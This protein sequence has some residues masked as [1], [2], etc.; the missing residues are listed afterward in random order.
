ME[1]KRQKID[2]KFLNK[3]RLFY[4]VM[5][6]VFENEEIEI[7][8]EDFTHDN[9]IINNPIGENILKY[10]YLPTSRFFS[11]D[12]YQNMVNKG[13]VGQ[14]DTTLAPYPFK[15]YGAYFGRIDLYTKL[16]LVSF[17]IDKPLLNG[18]NDLQY[19]EDF[20]PYFRDYANGFKDGYDNFENK[21]ISPFLPMFADKQDYINKVHEYLTKRIVFQHDWLNNHS[22]FVQEHAIQPKVGIIINAFED[23]QK[24]GYFYRAWTI[25][26]SNSQLFEPL[27]AETLNKRI[28]NDIAFSVLEWATIFYYADETKLLPAHNT[29]QERMKQFMIDHSVSTTFNSFKSK[30]YTAKKRIN[31]SNDYPIDKLKLILP[32]LEENY[33]QTVTKVKNDIMILE[34]EKHG[35]Q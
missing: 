10:Y 30:Y 33:K 18:N 29:T 9:L 16:S 20:K 17:K 35:Y 12:E 7:V 11:E 15:I 1:I 26:F 31:I 25:V 4:G 24:Q 27:F 19:F 8:P 32:Y 6:W 22:G 5:N 13:Y 3:L 28:Q 34:N 14:K 2:D 21:C 23:G